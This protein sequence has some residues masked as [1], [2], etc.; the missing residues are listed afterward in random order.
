MSEPLTLLGVAD[1]VSACG[2]TS[3]GR[4][5]QVET[6]FRGLSLVE[7]GVRFSTCATNQFGHPPR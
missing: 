2:W 3:E 1:T 7:K 5:M 4:D 6:I